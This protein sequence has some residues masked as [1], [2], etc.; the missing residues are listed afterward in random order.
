MATSLA[1]DVLT[2]QAGSGNRA[3]AILDGGGAGTIGFRCARVPDVTKSVICPATEVA[4]VYALTFAH[5]GLWYVWVYDDNGNS[6]EFEAVIVSG[7]MTRL[8]LM[9]ETLKSILDANRKG[10]EAY[11]RP[12]YPDVKIKQ[13][14][15]GSAANVHDWPSILITDG[16][17]SSQ[18]AFFPYGMEHTL[19]FMIE[20]IVLHDSEQTQMQATSRLGET[21]GNLLRL[22]EYNDFTLSDGSTVSLSH[23]QEMGVTEYPVGQKFAASAS[24]YWSGIVVVQDAGILPGS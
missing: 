21:I 13:V 11:L 5:P 19:H 4:G 23:V 22:P 6:T 16:S 17:Q 15:Y 10:F 1:I 18:Y 20:A 14:V 2:A 7:E 24:I 3:N 12:V 9:G 8:D